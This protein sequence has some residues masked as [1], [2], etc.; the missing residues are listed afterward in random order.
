MDIPTHFRKAI[1]NL[2]KFAS[3]ILLLLAGAI[4]GYLFQHPELMT[5]YL[6]Q[7][8]IASII[9]GGGIGALIYL[10]YGIGRDMEDV[11]D[12]IENVKISIDMSFK[13]LAKVI[14]QKNNPK[15]NPRR[16]EEEVK[17]SGWGAFAGMII[18]ASVGLLFGPAGVVVGGL[19]GAAIGNQIEYE[20]EKERKKREEERRKRLEAYLKA[21]KEKEENSS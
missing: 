7:E 13:N 9:I 1:E 12:G 5:P 3:I 15:N 11:K 21:I 20:Q 2:K 19:I 16:E 14:Q 4:I 6:T 8:T 18:G 17:T 10:T